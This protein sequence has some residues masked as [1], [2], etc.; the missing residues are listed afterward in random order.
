MKPA[1]L[2]SLLPVFL[3]FLAALALSVWIWQTSTHQASE[4]SRQKEAL[5]QSRASSQSR[6]LQSDAEKNLVLAHLAAYRQLE[7]RAAAEGGNRLA[8]LEAVQDA[9][10]AAGLYGMQYTLE[11]A[12]AVP[13]SAELE[14]TL[15]KLRL[16]LLTETDLTHFLGALQAK[17]TGLFRVKSC[18]LTRTGGLPPPMLN[19]PGLEAAC[20]LF[21]YNVR[22]TGAR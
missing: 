9:N 7:Q 17:Q 2:R 21:W 13:G 19:Q 6:L 3:L 18:T 22:K 8:W 14:R 5:Q 15:M 20:E 4:V 11:P 1:G 12:I 16:P 10:R